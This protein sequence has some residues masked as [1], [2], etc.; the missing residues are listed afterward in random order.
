MEDFLPILIFAVIMVVSVIRNMT[1]TTKENRQG[2]STFGEAFPQVDVL[3]PEEP[4]QKEQ[5]RLARKVTMKA[6]AE[7]KEA[8]SDTAEKRTSEKR[9][10]KV[11]LNGKSDAKRAFIYSEIFNKKYN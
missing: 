5:K 11:A 1:K 10:C 3:Q 4:E 9:G 6:A 7:E 8:F 2:T